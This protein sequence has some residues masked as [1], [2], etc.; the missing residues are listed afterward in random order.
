MKNRKNLV[1]LEENKEKFQKIHE[2][3]LITNSIRRNFWWNS[4]QK[5]VF[6]L[7]IF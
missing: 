2:I 4:N 3:K 5:F 6:F 7:R 1:K